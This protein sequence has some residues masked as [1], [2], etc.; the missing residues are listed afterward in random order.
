MTGESEAFEQLSYY[1][2]ERRDPAFIHQHVV[3]AFAA[4]TANEDTKPIKVIFALIGLYLYLE[5]GYTGKQVQRA[6][7]DLGRLK[8]AWPRWD[9]PAFRG[10]ITVS[11]VLDREPGAE[12]DEMIRTWCESV[13]RAYRSSHQQIAGLVQE[14][15]WRT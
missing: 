3:D 8:R 15:L 6:H 2:L 12:R 5:H 10:E 1:T 14:E 4:Q 13:W 11:D 9:L 7:T